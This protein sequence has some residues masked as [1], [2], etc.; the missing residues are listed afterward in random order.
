MTDL[1]KV[2]DSNSLKEV[3][4]VLNEKNINT[5]NFDISPLSFACQKKDIDLK[6]VQLLVSKGA[7]INFSSGY[8]PLI[9]AI[10]NHNLE[11]IDYLLSSG[12]DLNFLIAFTPLF[13]AYQEK[14]PK[15]ILRKFIELG[16]NV[17]HSTNFLMNNWDGTI[18]NQ[19]IRKNDYDLDFIQYLFSKGL[20]PN[21]TNQTVIHTAINQKSP[22]SVIKLLATKTNFWNDKVI[23]ILVFCLRS[24]LDNK[25]K[26]KYLTIL[27]DNGAPVYALYN[28]RKISVQCYD[29]YLKDFLDNYENICQEF[30][31]FYQKSELTDFIITSDNGTINCHKQIIEMRLGKD[32]VEKLIPFC[33]KKEKQEVENMMK[34]IY[35]GIFEGNP[36]E[37]SVL[38]NEIGMSNELILSK[39]RRFGLVRDLEAWSKKEEEKDFAIIVEDQPIKVHKLILAIRS[40]LFFN[41]F[42]NVKDDSNQVR[43]YSQ[44][45]FGAIK[46][47]IH[48]FYL[49]KLPEDIT[50][51]EFEELENASEF[52][53]MHSKNSF[54]YRQNLFDF[55]L[56]KD[57]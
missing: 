47:L 22:E 5:P 50:Q 18:L 3:E 55:P 11:L 31:E 19:M 39:S 1:F 27:I 45:T 7:D 23:P 44:K 26:L 13:L 24:P 25:E 15:E 12:V 49:D 34:W 8:R 43:D 38:L 41:M 32:L 6:I 16:D 54:L 37:T 9:F 40:E 33:E 20:D 17:N 10:K 46:A 21:I 2:I 52:Y 29:Q 35:S 28:K 14:L 51:S 57:D 42:V 36:E 4:K 53:Q 48:Y 30:L 56:K